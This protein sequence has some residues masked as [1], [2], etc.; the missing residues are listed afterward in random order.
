[1]IYLQLMKTNDKE[2]FYSISKDKKKSPGY[3]GFTIKKRLDDRG[4]TQ[5]DG[6]ELRAVHWSYVFKIG[7]EETA[8]IEF[9]RDVVSCLFLPESI[10][11]FKNYIESS[12]ND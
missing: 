12:L 1:M 11:Y 2:Y 6:I 8:S 10:H 5:I 9:Y 7:K 3:Y 4:K